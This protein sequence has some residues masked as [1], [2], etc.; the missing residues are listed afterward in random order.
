M[1][2]LKNKIHHIKERTYFQNCIDC[3][4]IMIYFQKLHFHYAV[5]C[6][7]KCFIC[8]VALR[9]LSSSVFVRHPQWYVYCEILYNTMDFCQ[10]K[11]N[12]IWSCKWIIWK[13]ITEHTWWSIGVLLT[14]HIRFC[15]CNTSMSKQILACFGTC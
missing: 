7:V 15:M 9:L 11:L 1:W 13:R 4:S 5:I 8:S 12:L 2:S 6:S 3:M 10:S 14:G